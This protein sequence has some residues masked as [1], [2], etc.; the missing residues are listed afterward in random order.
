MMI[1]SLLPPP[2]HPSGVH[3][4]RQQYIQNRI[5]FNLD[6]RRALDI[7]MPFVNGCARAQVAAK[8]NAFPFIIVPPSFRPFRFNATAKW[9]AMT[10]A[11]GIG[12]P[13]PSKIESPAF[14]SRVCI[15]ARV[16]IQQAGKA[17]KAAIQ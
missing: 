5:V 14:T 10:V 16:P 7:N 6:I 3:Y 15:Y 4:S 1:F 12:Q 11:H 2:P 9:I 13:R 8:Q 17:R